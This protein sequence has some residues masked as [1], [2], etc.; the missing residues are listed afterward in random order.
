MDSVDAGSGPFK[1]VEWKKDQHL[2]LEKF[3]DYFVEGRPFLDRVIWRPIAEDTARTTALRNKEIDIMLQ[4]APKDIMKLQNEPDLQVT[5]VTGTFWEYLGIN[6]TKGPLQDRRVRQAI[7][8]A[9]D[10]EAINQVVKFGQAEVLTGGPIP[11][12]H[13]ASADLSIYPKQ[14]LDKAREL[15]AE[16]GYADGFHVT[17]K[18]S[19]VKEQV[20]A[21][22]IIKQQLQEV[23]IEVEVLALESGVFFEQLGQQDFE[24]TVVGWVGFVDP[25]EFLYN[26]FHTGEVWNQQGYSNPEVD[27]LLE[28]GRITTDLQERKEIYARAQ[29]LIVEDAPM[30]FLYMNPQTSAYWNHVQGFDVNPTV[31]TI[32]LRDTWIA[33]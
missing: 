6:T 24:L 3:E 33:R 31:T 15:L 32:S 17:L 23:G 4:V 26:I 11:P 7:A 30:A 9:L 10:R 19:P 25:D 2:I 14:D 21:A 5:S 27:A 20:D 18:V 12:T 28:Q 1:L 13:W 8:H 22:Q 16:A 29:Q